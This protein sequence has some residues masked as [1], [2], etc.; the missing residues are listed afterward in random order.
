MIDKPAYGLDIA[1][2][3]AY[4]CNVFCIDLKIS[5]RKNVSAQSGEE[6]KLILSIKQQ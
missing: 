2:Q 3:M 6:V 5:I 1:S 4:F